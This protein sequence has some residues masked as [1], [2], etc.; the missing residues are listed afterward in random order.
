LNKNKLVT[1]LGSICL[2]LI[3]AALP[4][5][6]ACAKPAPP[7]KPAWP[8]KMVWATVP[9]GTTGYLNSVGISQLITRELEVMTSVQPGTSA[10]EST[11]RVLDGR[12]NLGW[13]NSVTGRDAYR[14]TG[15]FEKQEKGKLRVL[16]GNYIIAFEYFT[17]VA[18][19]IEKFE[20]I[21]GKRFMCV[22]AAKA[23]A[24]LLTATLDA[25]GMTRDDFVA[26][27]RLAPPQQVTALKDGTADIARFPGSPPI[28]LFQELATSRPMRLLSLDEDKVKAVRQKY[29]IYLPCPIPAGTYKGQDEDVLVLGFLGYTAVT[30][31]FPE[32]LAYQILTVIW[33]NWEELK[34]IHSVFKNMTP[35]LAVMDPTAPY[36]AGAVKYYKEKGVWTAEYDSRQQKLLAE[37]G[38]TK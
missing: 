33:D 8:E 17:L 20:D 30:K 4:L 16:C 34:K 7:P 12:A 1:L 37:L 2:V 32:D 38:E 27:P 23:G 31:D 11:M 6:A 29:P 25:Y 26:L 24:D 21:R 3:L 22:S 5:M 14:A 9:A 13:S 36:H 28:P 35:E 18:S 15:V 10:E 19:G